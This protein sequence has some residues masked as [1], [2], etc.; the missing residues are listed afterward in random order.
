M[1]KQ[2]WTD[3][4]MK[5]VNMAGT[6]ILMNL[7]FLVACLPIVTIGQAWCALLTAIRYNI[8]GDSWFDGFK[9]GYKTRFW[10]GIIVW[11]ICLPVCYF[12]MRDVNFALQDGNV[13][14]LVVSGLFFTFFAMLTTSFLMLN[15][16]IPTSV[17][18]WIKNAL[19]FFSHP[20]ELLAGAVLFWLPA[21]VVF[22]WDA[23]L[24]YQLAIIFV[25]VYCTLSALISTMLM[26]NPLIQFLLQAREDGTLI[27]EEGAQ[28]VPR[29]DEEYEEEEE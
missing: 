9:F 19:N 5:F 4:V 20:L 1:E 23:F 10:R 18:Q 22:L 14:N 6:A 25:A 7:L 17:N 21:V 3:K 8:R 13:P 27:A 12:F 29:D 24:F 28:P 2:T 15:V 26:K 16:Y 11:C